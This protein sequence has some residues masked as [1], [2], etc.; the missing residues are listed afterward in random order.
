MPGLLLSA[1]PGA[2]RRDRIALALMAATGLPT[3]V[4]VT[5]IGVHDHVLST[6]LAAALVGAGLL[7]VLVFPVV[8]TGLLG[9]LPVVPDES[10]DDDATW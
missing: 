6:G 7:S 10:V 4:A 1:P 2:D 3:I 8:A 5:G 9:K